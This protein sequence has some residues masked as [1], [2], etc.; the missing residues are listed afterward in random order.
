MAVRVLA[1]LGE[2]GHTVQMLKLVALLG[3]EY[4][5]SYLMPQ[6]D[7]T[8]EAKI[9]IPGPVYRAYI[10]RGKSSIDWRRSILCLFQEFMVL[11][12]VRPQVILSVGAGI[13]VP[14]SVFGRLT[15]VRVIHVE[16][17]SR[18]HSL[19][20]TGRIMYRVA[21]LFFVQWETLWKRYPKAIYAGRLL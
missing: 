2:G 18:V 6:N 21:H 17:A 3:D 10:P 1:I 11:W 12:R 19:S 14:I 5:Y 15:G 8:S 13:A 9:E 7:R 20:L 16:S 4:E